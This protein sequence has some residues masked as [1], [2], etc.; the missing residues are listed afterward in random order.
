[1]RKRRG[2]GGRR[3]RVPGPLSRS[4]V[5]MAILIGVGLP[6][7]YYAYGLHVLQGVASLRA[8]EMAHRMAAALQDAP[9]PGGAPASEI[10][11]VLREFLALPHRDVTSVQLLD[12]AGQPITIPGSVPPA[13]H[14]WPRLPS[15]SGTAPIL[16][17]RRPIGKVE[18]QASQENL[19]REAFAFFVVCA[20]TSISVV[21]LTPPTLKRRS[22]SR[23]RTAF[24]Q[25][26]TP[27]EK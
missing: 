13:P 7:G 23:T 8:R 27:S 4:L 2:G 5:A 25:T 26:P 21:I 9:Q 14:L 19:L 17:Q 1:M 16:H 6:V 12:A 10:R 22:G 18:V 20:L 3:R 15:L 11:S 24:R